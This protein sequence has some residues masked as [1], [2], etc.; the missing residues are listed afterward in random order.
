LSISIGCRGGNGTHPLGSTILQ[1]HACGDAAWFFVFIPS[2][3]ITVDRHKRR[4]SG[5]GNVCGLIASIIVK[6]A[7]INGY[8]LPL[9]STKFHRYR[10]CD[11]R[12]LF[13]FY[14]HILLITDRLN[15]GAWT[16][17]IADF[18]IV[19]DQNRPSVTGILRRSV[20]MGKIIGLEKRGEVW[21]Y[22]RWVPTDVRH[23]IGKDELVKSLYTKDYR[24]AVERYKTVSI[25]IEPCLTMPVSDA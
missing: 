2:I 11:A 22:R 20:V 16:I 15:D 4:V 10:C 25:K 13:Y 7:V 1:D 6:P 8:T 18:L 12:Y 19:F 9:S 5:A 23:I 21:R 24:T 3:T 17:L 14:P